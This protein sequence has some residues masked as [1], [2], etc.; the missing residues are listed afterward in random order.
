MSSDG[1]DPNLSVQQR[2]A[3]QHADAF[4]LLHQHLVVKRLP[5]TT[6][7]ICDAHAVL[8]RDGV[9]RGDGVSCQPWAV[10]RGK[11]LCWLPPLP[12]QHLHQALL[13]QLGCRVQ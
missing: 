12:A 2:E 10:S 4:Q 6:A 9:Q 11:M 7:I 5:L 13:V 1:V 8:M 3:V